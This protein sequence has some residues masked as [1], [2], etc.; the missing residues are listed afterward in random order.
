MV[1]SVTKSCLT[2]ATP[3]TVAC[4]APLSMGFSRQEYWSGLSFPSPGGVFPTQG[5]NPHFLYSCIADGYFLPLPRQMSPWE[6]EHTPLVLARRE[7]PSPVTHPPGDITSG[8]ML[9]INGCP[10]SEWKL[11]SP[12]KQRRKRKCVKKKEGFL[13]RWLSS[14]ASVCQCRRCRFDP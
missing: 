7:S 3:W 5:S 14:K 8:K 13:P 2:L 12:S 4:Q 6:E 9:A 10:W 11:I 1:V